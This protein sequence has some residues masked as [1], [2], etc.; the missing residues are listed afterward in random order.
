[1]GEKTSRCG[2]HAMEE[3]KDMESGEKARNRALGTSED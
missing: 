2:S 1:M 3:G